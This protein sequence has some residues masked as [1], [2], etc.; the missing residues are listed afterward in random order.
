MKKLTLL[1]ITFIAFSICTTFKLSAQGIGINA[2]GAH[3]DSSAIIDISS[4]TQGALIPRMSTTQR[5]ALHNPAAGLMIFNT[6]CNTINFNIGTSASPNWTQVVTTNNL[7]AAIS[8]AISPQGEFCYG[9]SVTFTATPTNGGSSPSYQWKVNG[10]NVGTDSN[11]YTTSTLSNGDVVSC[12]LTSN[13]PCVATPTVTSNPLTMIVNYTPPAAPASIGNPVLVAHNSGGITFSIPAVASATSYTWTIS[14][15]GIVSSGQGTPSITAFFG[16]ETSDSVLVVANNNCGASPASGQIIYV[17]GVTYPADTTGR[18][19]TIKTL[20]VQT[21]GNYTIQAY[22]AQG[23]AFCGG[24]GGNGASM[25]GDFSINAGTVLNI[26]VGQA[27]QANGG[28]GGG[29]SFVVKSAG[30]VPL[31]IAGGGGGGG[32][33]GPGLPGNTGTAGTDGTGGAQGTHGDNGGGGGGAAGYG[34][35]GGGGLCGDGGNAGHDYCSGGTGGNGCANG[36]DAACAIC[37]GTKGFSFLNGG[38]GGSASCYPSIGDGGFGGGG[39]SIHGNDCGGGGGG[40][41][42]GGGGGYN[43]QHGYG[44]GG[45]SYNIGTNQSNSSGTQAGN[46]IVVITYF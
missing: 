4:T 26:L 16:S 35:A 14:G 8:I 12:V 23:A 1:S 3:P 29:G 41:S 36:T 21:T 32:C 5:D 34:G 9:T 46:G 40:Y 45:G 10:G 15:G 2:T 43:G 22:G 38:A 39:A 37:T 18:I 6:D 13:A 28:G 27:A 24:N 20:N 25:Q 42:G 44:G 30:N 19:G 7:A 33:N 31:I 17:G 11:T